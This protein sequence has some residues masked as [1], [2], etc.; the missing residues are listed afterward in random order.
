MSAN[1]KNLHA[2][3]LTMALGL[4][5]LLT[6]TAAAQD[7]HYWTNQYGTRAELLG[8]LVVG[9]VVDLS[10]TYYNPGALAHVSNP[11]L[12]LTTDAWELVGITLETGVGDEFDLNSTRLRAA[13]RIFAIQVP[14]NESKSK[15]AV[16]VLSRHDFDLEVEAGTV[17]PRDS[18]VS[19]ATDFGASAEVTRRARL[20]EGWAGFTWAYPLADRVGLGATGYIAIRSQRIRRQLT[21]SAVDTL[22]N[23]TA[24]ID[25]DDLSYW[26]VRALAKVGLQFNLAPVHLGVTVTTPGLSLFGQGETKVSASDVDPV[27]G[28]SDGSELTANTQKGLP[29]TYRSPLSIAV[30]AEY[31]FGRTSLYF[32]GE[33]FNGVGAF[34]IIDSDPFL[35]QSSGDTISVDI[36][37]ELDPVINLG[38]AVEHSLSG[39]VELYGAVFSDRS[40]F[41][42][43]AEDPLPIATWDIL[44]FTVGAA[45]QVG[46]IDL[47]LGASHG[48]GNGEAFPIDFL[49]IPT[50]FRG[51]Y[52]SFKLIVGFQIG[53]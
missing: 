10:A 26:N 17:I 38:V 6:R 31:D 1:C 48:H 50:D 8:G 2:V 18:I 35:G 7:A 49:G 33:W 37:Q 52:R 28:E 41:D 46:A 32:T 23:G 40:A 45:F 13:P 34:K 29:S 22:G 47:T 9:S 3:G 20:A 27:S 14:S 15:F 43:D 24:T 16:S 30:G 44:H 11:G 51:T 19:G 21:A 5:L 12:I 42:R 25:Y 53:F 36:I 4:A 39:G